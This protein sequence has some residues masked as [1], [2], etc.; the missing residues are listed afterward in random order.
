MKYVSLCLWCLWCCLLY[1]AIL[2]LMDM[3]FG[4]FGFGGALTALTR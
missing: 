3:I 2:Y 1:Y 4:A